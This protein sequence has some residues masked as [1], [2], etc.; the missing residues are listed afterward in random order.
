MECPPTS[1]QTPTVYYKTEHT[2]KA[3]SESRK[4]LLSWW[5]QKERTEPFTKLV[6]DRIDSEPYACIL[7]LKSQNINEGEKIL[8]ILQKAGILCKNVPET[9]QGNV[10]EW[11]LDNRHR[12]YQ[13]E[14]HSYQIK[15]LIS[16]SG[17]YGDVFLAKDQANGTKIAIKILRI[18]SDKEHKQFEKIQKL[19]GHPNIVQYLGSA[20]L[21]GKTWI[22]MEY[23]EGEVRKK[24]SPWTK[25]LEEQYRSAISFLCKAKIYERENEGENV[26]ITLIDGVPT[27]KL[28]DFGT[29][30][31]A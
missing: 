11:I 8:N 29:L 23:I 2:A 14:G 13:I 10:V 17:C 1:Y 6:A 9:I 7:R 22:A 31:R 19:G 27:V 30:A 25:E 26:M 21:F 20:T 18:E 15:R 4:E 5:K 3:V 16:S 28:I 12:I 24:Y